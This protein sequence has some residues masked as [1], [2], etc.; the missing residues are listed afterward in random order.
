MAYIREYPPPSR[1]LSAGTKGVPRL[2]E[3]WLYMNVRTVFFVSFFF[4]E[5]ISDVISF[6]RVKLKLL[7]LRSCTLCLLTDQAF[8]KRGK[9][10]HEA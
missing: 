5:K 10:G 8:Q 7:S 1:T 9:Q 6:K 2:K 4:I 3:S